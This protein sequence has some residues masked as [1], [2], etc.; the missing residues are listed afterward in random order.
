ML[1]YLRGQ[2][3]FQVR[4]YNSAIIEYEKCMKHPNFQ[5]ELLFSS[6]GL[7][8]CA[9]GRLNDG[10]ELLLKACR[11]YEENRWKFDSTYTLNLA[12]ETLSALN[13]VTTYVE[14][15]EGKQIIKRKRQL[16]IG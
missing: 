5:N 1:S 6:Y 2:K 7:A 9:A 8:L 13:Y 3:M 11:V 12:N 14:N 10:L 4:D 16:S 15:D